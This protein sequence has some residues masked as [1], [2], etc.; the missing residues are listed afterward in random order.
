MHVKKMMTIAALIFIILVTTVCI[1][2]AVGEIKDLHDASGLK[3]TDDGKLIDTYD[4]DKEIGNVTPISSVDEG[5]ELL[6]NYDPELL[7]DILSSDPLVTEYNVEDSTNSSN[8]GIYFMFGHDGDIF[9]G[10]VHSMGNGMLKR[11]TEFGKY[12]AVVK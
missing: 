1:V 9:L 11:I 6:Y 4:N 3:V 8:S 7:K 5:E 10:F 12:N 2:S